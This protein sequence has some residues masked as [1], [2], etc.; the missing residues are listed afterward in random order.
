MESGNKLHGIEIAG[1]ESDYG[2]Q[3]NPPAGNRF[4]HHTLFPGEDFHR[5]PYR[6]LRSSLWQYLDRVSPDVIVLPGWT[7]PGLAGLAWAVK[8]GIPRVLM[9]D[10]QK[11]DRRQTFIRTRMK[12]L[13]VRR[14]QA[15]FA[16]GAPHV[17]WLEELGLPPGKCQTGCDV[18][19]NGHFRA[20]ADFRRTVATMSYEAPVLLSCLRLIPRKNVTG[21]L[22]CLALRSPRWHW[23]IAGDGP[24]RE[25][26]E[27]R[28][29]ELGLTNRVELAGRVQ[30]AELPAFYRSGDVYI[31]PSTTEQWGLAVN[32]AM[33]SGL[34]VLVANR[35][36]CHEDLVQEGINGFT[37]DPLDQA[38]IAAALERM[39]ERH[40]MWSAMGVAS[41]TIIAEWDLRRFASGFWKSCQLAVAAGEK[42][43][44]GI[45]DRLVRICL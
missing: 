3:F 6:R 11:T 22:E 26:I 1:F 8:R 33:A 2:W 20:A 9:S 17:R 23:R 44:G 29:H 19:D 25:E 45:A 35:C 41:Q 24:Q 15:A 16:A 34:P 14:F 40:D 36:G 30:Y 27:Q 38:G 31:Q 28:V 10:S 21:I 42:F 32:E 13:L 43:H 7:R 5:I 37:F 12:R 39:W 18:V 4:V